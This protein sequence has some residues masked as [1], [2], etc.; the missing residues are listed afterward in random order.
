M[1]KFDIHAYLL[2][3]GV[4][5]ELLPGKLETLKAVM[6]GQA[7]AISFENIDV[8]IES[9]LLTLLTLLPLLDP[10]NPIYSAV[11]QCNH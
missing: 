11:C 10:A 2:R 9:T 7:R 8:V 5:K 6:E 1:Y 4:A 3:I